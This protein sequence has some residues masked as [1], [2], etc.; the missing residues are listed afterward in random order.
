M[1]VGGDILDSR[2][3][4]NYKTNMF[5][6]FLCGFNIKAI[7]MHEHVM[8]SQEHVMNSQEHVKN[9]MNI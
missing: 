7:V 3:W 6:Y 1:R 9:D 8:N 5:S 4:E 2:I